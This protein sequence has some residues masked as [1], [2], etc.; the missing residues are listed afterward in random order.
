MAKKI[1]LDQAKCTGLGICESLSPAYFEVN[2]D[3]DMVQ[4]LQIEVAE[5]DLQEVQEACDG[6][7][8]EAI[9][10]EEV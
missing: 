4:L 2:E 6:C 3:G 8:N 10:L 5:G 9:R 1:V 7:P